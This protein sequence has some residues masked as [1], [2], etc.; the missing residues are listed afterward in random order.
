MKKIFMALVAIA[1]VGVF[2]SCS[3]GDDKNVTVENLYKD[4]NYEYYCYVS[5]TYNG[6]SILGFS[7]GYLSTISYTKSAKVTNC[8]EYSIRYN[9]QLYR[10]NSSYSSSS[11][12]G[13]LYLRRVGSHW[14]YKTDSTRDWN[15][16]SSFKISGSPEDSS[17]TVTLS[18]NT[19]LKFNRL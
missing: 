6:Y 2:A 10:S 8:Q 19:I 12:S 1:C 9:F 13:E 17:F 15:Y 16:S 18:S 14:Y 5:G 11:T 4:V 3:D 7:E